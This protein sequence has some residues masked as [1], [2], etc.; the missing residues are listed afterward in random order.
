MEIVGKQ[1][2]EEKSGGTVELVGEGGDVVSVH[3][4]SDETAI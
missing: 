2:H 1:V 3:M 4:K